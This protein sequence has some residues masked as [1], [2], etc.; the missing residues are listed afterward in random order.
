MFDLVL[1]ICDRS[2]IKCGSVCLLKQTVLFPID[3][4]F[5]LLFAHWITQVIFFLNQILDV[6][7]D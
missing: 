1:G 6:K 2:G 7:F 5:F 4:F 3:F